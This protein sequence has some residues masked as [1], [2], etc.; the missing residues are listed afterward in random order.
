MAQHGEILVKIQNG[1]A[2]IKDC[3][4]FYQQSNFLVIIFNFLVFRIYKVLS[5]ISVSEILFDFFVIK[6][7]DS[8]LLLEISDLKNKIICI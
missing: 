7:F 2:E 5:N 4:N 1:W 3:G 6:S 8:K